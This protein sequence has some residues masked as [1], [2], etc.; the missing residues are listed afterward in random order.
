MEVF[1]FCCVL[2]VFFIIDILIRKK[3][4]KD[5]WRALLDLGIF[6]VVI[7]FGGLFFGLLLVSFLRQAF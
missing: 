5:P 6:V 7:Y 3:K 1:I 4:G 2:I